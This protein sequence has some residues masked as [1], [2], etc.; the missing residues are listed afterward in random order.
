MNN[1]IRVV[2][3]YAAGSSAMVLENP[4]DSVKWVRTFL[5]VLRGWVVLVAVPDEVN[6]SFLHYSDIRFVVVVSHSW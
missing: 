3:S 5:A 4:M 1:I 6:P 2:G